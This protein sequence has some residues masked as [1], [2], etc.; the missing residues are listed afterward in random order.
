MNSIVKMNVKF[1]FCG[2]TV[3]GTTEWVDR[4]TK[5]KAIENER[6]GEKKKKN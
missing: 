2:K 6:E 5:R 3:K 1:F 4:A